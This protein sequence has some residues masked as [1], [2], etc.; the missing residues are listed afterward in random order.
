MAAAEMN[1]CDGLDLC[2]L[3]SGPNAVMVCTPLVT[4]TRTEDDSDGRNCSG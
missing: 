2:E 4:M 1:Y 3:I